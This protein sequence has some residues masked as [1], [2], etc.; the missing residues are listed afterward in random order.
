MATETDR[1]NTR[2][3]TC[4]HIE[5]DVFPTNF[6]RIVLTVEPG[7]VPGYEHVVVLELCPLCS[8]IVMGV[9]AAEIMKKVVEDTVHQSIKGF[10]GALKRAA[11]GGE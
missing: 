7:D 8:N 11:F 1:G 2:H 5:Q 4:P 10:S 3:I 9:F 6:K